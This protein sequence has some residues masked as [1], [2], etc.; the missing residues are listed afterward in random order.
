MKLIERVEADEEEAGL[1]LPRI[2]VESIPEIEPRR[3]YVLTS[4]LMV[5][6]EVLAVQCWHRMEDR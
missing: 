5:K 6:L 2:V 3:L 4:R 1:P